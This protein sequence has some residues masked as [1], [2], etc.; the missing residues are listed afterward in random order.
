MV[1][2]LLLVRSWQLNSQREPE[3]ITHKCGGGGGAGEAGQRQCY[4]AGSF[5]KFHQ[6][7]HLEA[8]AQDYSGFEK[9]KQ[10]GGIVRTNV[11][12]N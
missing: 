4:K 1:T 9:V 7:P 2:D 5:L 3:V 11:G 10:A 8:K 12:E 6:N